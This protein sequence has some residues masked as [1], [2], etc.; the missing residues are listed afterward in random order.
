MLRISQ[1]IELRFKKKESHLS[2][3]LMKGFALALSLHL[4]LYF[5]FPI[6][7]MTHGEKSTP[8]RPIAVEVD[9]RADRTL[10]AQAEPLPTPFITSPKNPSCT[11]LYL[12]TPL[13][14]DELV[15]PSSTKEHPLT[16]S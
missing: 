12:E 10:V 14:Q 2:R 9:L 6:T 7:R 8:L 3:E 1:A 16:E 13:L 4:V 5:F 15:L 11:T